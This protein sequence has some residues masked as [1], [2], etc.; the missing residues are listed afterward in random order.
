MIGGDSKAM[1]TSSIILIL[2]LILQVILYIY[3]FT[4]YHK[5]KDRRGPPGRG[6]CPY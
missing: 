5:L 4:T 2:I 1:S 3:A 6:T